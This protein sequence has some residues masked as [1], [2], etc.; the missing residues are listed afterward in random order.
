MKCRFG[1]RE[2]AKRD[3]TVIKDAA[4]LAGPDVDPEWKVCR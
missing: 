2:G 4:G 1:D 3:M